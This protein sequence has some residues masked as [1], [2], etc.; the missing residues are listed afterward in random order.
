[1][2]AKIQ[3]TIDELLSHNITRKEAVETLLNLN[4][5]MPA[6]LYFKARRHKLNLSLREVSIEAGISH[7]TIRRIERGCNC[8]YFNVK[9]LD[10]WYS[11]LG[12]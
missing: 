6:L 11:S 7:S 2:E 8:D 3:H 10:D 1:M 12:V 9:A 4:R 5:S